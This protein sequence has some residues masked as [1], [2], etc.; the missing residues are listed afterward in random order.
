MSAQQ[1][2]IDLDAGDE[3]QIQQAELSEVRDRG[4]PGR[5]EIESVRADHETAE[6]QADQPGMRAR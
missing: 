4:T 2:K 5:Y 3:H 6:Q 1:R